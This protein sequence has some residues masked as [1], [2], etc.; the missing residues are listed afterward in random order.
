MTTS[1]QRL[2][3]DFSTQGVRAQGFSA[4]RFLDD[5]GHAVQAN[6]VP[7]ALI[8]MGALWMLMGGGRATAAA[9]LLS[10][11]AAGVTGAAAGVTGAL[12][13]VGTAV[14]GAVNSIGQNVSE[15]ASAANDAAGRTIDAAG[16]AAADATNYVAST[17]SNAGSKLREQS[18]SAG[19]SA[20]AFA[21]S[22]Q[23]NLTQ[24][25][26]RQPLLV[27]VIGLA[28]GAAIATAFPKTR[29]EEETMGDQAAAMKEKVETFVSD[30]AENLGE[31]ATRTVEAMKEEAET[32]GLTPSALKQGVASIRDK[33]VSAAGAV[34][35]KDQ[36]LR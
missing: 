36:S 18:G 9:G 5:L 27:G 12:A 11:G 15:L 29:L 8:G 10:A 19:A 2:G 6:P 30:Q 16:D 24:T 7:A 31:V 4:Q 25:F 14:K 23:G 35:R 28:I 1:Q 3:Q 33:A 26:E 20:S 17:A 34:R 32:Q 21:G 22:V 13:P